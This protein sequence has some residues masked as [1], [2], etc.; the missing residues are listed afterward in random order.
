MMFFSMKSIEE[1]PRQHDCALKCQPLS[2]SKGAEWCTVTQSLYPSD[3]R[4]ENSLPTCKSTSFPWGYMSSNSST[5]ALVCDHLPERRDS[6]YPKG[7]T[8]LHDKI[9]RHGLPTHPGDGDL[10]SRTH[11]AHASCTLRHLCALPWP[12]CRL[13]YRKLSEAGRIVG[14]MVVIPALL[15]CP[16]W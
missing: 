12:A 14:T 4:C 13:T 11:A 16:A 8:S 3:V 15:H 7:Q 9:S 6:F 10:G 2:C 5:S 1:K